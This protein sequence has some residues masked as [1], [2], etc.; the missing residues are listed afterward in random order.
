MARTKGDAFAFEVYRRVVSITEQATKN[1]QGADVQVYFSDT[2]DPNSW[3]NVRKYVQQG[4][5][6]GARMRN[7]FQRGFDQGYERI[8]GIGTDLP[9]LSTE[10]LSEG[11]IALESHDTVFGPSEDGG[12]YLIGM[13]QML[14]MVFEEK[15][16]STE[17]VLSLTLEQ[18]K[19]NNRTVVTLCTLN[20]IDTLE[21]LEASWLGREFN[22]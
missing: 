17:D 6:L 3:S 11:L 21:D 5:D 7:A 4:A 9:D 20:D 18:L 8:I 1:F 22:L 15:P 13:R 19:A 16:W 2:I 12:Y 14:P 10:V